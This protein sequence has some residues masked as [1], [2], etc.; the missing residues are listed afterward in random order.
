MEQA[1]EVVNVV[2]YTALAAVAVRFAMRHRSA[3]GTWAAATFVVLATIVV[4]GLIAPAATADASRWTAGALFT[5]LLIIML[6]TFPYLLHRFTR[7]LRGRPGLMDRVADVG[8]AVLVV[9]T[10]VV[11]PFPLEGDAQPGWVALYTVYFM[12]WWGVLLAGVGWSLW[13]L[14]AGQAGIVRGRMRLMAVAALLMNLALLGGVLET[15][16]GLSDVLGW[17]AAVGF[18][19]G[20]QPLPMLRT[21][22]PPA[23]RPRCA[24]P[25]WACS[26]PVAPPRPPRRWPGRRPPSWVAPGRGSAPWTGR[27]WPRRDPSRARHWRSSAATR[28]WR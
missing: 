25:R 19:M 8:L 9:A 10:L 17:L 27:C 26:P 18:L 6:G 23:T 12:V 14:G 21:I 24:R 11:P 20:L 3:A 7:E 4:M 16:Q 15:F 1:L 22:W 5:D 13:R 28:W 2:V